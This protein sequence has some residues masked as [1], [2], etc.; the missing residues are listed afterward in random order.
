MKTTIPLLT[1][2]NWDSTLFSNNFHVPDRIDKEH[3]FDLLMFECGEMELLYSEPTVFALNLETWSKKRLKVWEKLLDTLEYDYN[4]IYNYD[5]FEDYTDK[6]SGNRKISS[7][8]NSKN[9]GEDT[10]TEK[11]SA[12]NTSDWENRAKSNTEYGGT[13]TQT[14][15]ETENSG[16]EFT[17][18]AHLRGNIGVTTTQQMIDE[19]RRIVNYTVEDTIIHD[20]KYHFLLGVY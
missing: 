19:Q 14:G 9:G 12:F 20:F 13:N 8:N 15:T 1:L 5:R 10:T 18:T 6:G 16:N 2:Y 3:L 11:V 7:T 4:P 17:H